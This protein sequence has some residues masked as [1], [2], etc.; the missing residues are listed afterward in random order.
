MFEV[1]VIINTKIYKIIKFVI[2]KCPVI[3]QDILLEE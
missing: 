3:L 1:M 2:I